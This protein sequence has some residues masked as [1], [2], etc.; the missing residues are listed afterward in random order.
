MRTANYLRRLTLM[1]RL[2]SS[3]KRSM[4]FALGSM[5]GDTSD[6]DAELL[7]MAAEAIIVIASD[8]RERVR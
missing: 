4:R 1:R 2:R 3:A 6:I 5:G 8:S 7:K